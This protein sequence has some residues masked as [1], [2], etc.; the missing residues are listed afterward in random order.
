MRRLVA[1]AAS[2]TVFAV[3]APAQAAIVDVKITKTAFSP[4]SV[5]INFADTVKWT[6]SDTANHQI[7]ADNGSFA[8]PILKPGTS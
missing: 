4:S 8:S 6:N 2:F 3:A 7:V 1:L 5:R